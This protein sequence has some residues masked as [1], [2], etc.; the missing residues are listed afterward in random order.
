[1]ENKSFTTTLVVDQ[2]AKEVFDAINNVRGW[3]SEDVKGATNKLNEE[4]SYHYEDIH[5]AKIRIIEFVPDQKVVW[6][7]VDN[8]F[9]FIKDKKEWTDTKI[10]FEIEKEGK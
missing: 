4:F 2:T 5:R 9:N 7:V 6:H 3:W 1:M 8:Y 10:I